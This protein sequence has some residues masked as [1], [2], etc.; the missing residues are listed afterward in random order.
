MKSIIIR[1]VEERM[2]ENWQKNAE[3]A[4]FI[5]SAVMPFCCRLLSLFTL[6]LSSISDK[7]HFDRS[8]PGG[9]TNIMIRLWEFYAISW[10]LTSGVILRVGHAISVICD[11]FLGTGKFNI[12]FEGVR[13]KILKT[14]KITPKLAKQQKADNLSVE[15]LFAS[16]QEKHQKPTEL[17]E[18]YRKSIDITPTTD[19][20]CEKAM[21]KLH[22]SIGKSSA[23]INFHS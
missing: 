11:L 21:G 18:K 14:H 3:N 2:N 7:F 16:N 6:E 12:N 1:I 13:N 17:R 10:L 4:S 15:N 8:Q 22:D 5:R 23:V 9:M 19:I 20:N